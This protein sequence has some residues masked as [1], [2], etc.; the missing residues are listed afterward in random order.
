MKVRLL[1]GI[2]LF[3]QFDVGKLFE[4]L[5]APKRCE[6][7]VGVHLG[8]AMDGFM[9]V[10]PTCGQRFKRLGDFDRRLVSELFLDRDMQGGVDERIDDRSI[11]FL[12]R[13]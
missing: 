11:H 12:G 10:H 4:A 1:G 9:A 7:K 3:E 8:D 6:I 2:E 13:G 5:T